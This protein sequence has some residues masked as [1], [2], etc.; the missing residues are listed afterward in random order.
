MILTISTVLVKIIGFLFT[1]PLLN[2]LGAEGMGYFYTAYEIYGLF[3]VV[4]TTGLP[5]AAAK[6]VSEAVTKKNNSLADA[7]FSASK[8]LFY[9]FGLVCAVAMFFFADGLADLLKNPNAALAMRAL[10]P[11][12]FFQAVLAAYRGYFQGKSNMIPT[13]ATQIIEAVLKLLFGV[14]AAYALLKL[15]YSNA[16]AA[17]GAIAGVSIGSV[18]AVIYLLFYKKKD[19][20]YIEGLSSLSTD[21]NNKHLIKSLISIAVPIT[22]GTAIFNLIGIIDTGIIMRRL[23]DA[24]GLSYYESNWLFGVYGNAKK[25]FNL[26]IAFIVPLSSSVI[27]ALSAALTRKDQ[28]SAKGLTAQSLKVTSLLAFPSGAGL[29]ALAY[30]IMNLIYF[31]SSEEIA[32]GAQL[33]SV[34]GIAVVFSSLVLITSSIIQVGYDV[35]YPAITMTIGG[36]I[37]I[38]LCWILVGNSDIGIIGAPI[39]TCVCYAVTAILNIILICRK[40]INVKDAMIIFIKIAACSVIMA[41]A[42]YNLNGL[43]VRAINAKIAC[44][45]SMILGVIIYGVL[46]VTTKLVT[47]DDFKQFPKGEKIANIL[48]IK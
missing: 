4:F 20:K 39:S 18:V 27:P 8:F 36:I 48:H 40:L 31:K 42:A 23:Q 32:I 19:D 1:I 35:K 30:P 13:A 17:A 16:F 38:G 21:I 22:L 14:G 9:L 7:I 37:K 26:P 41:V 47:R 43:L 25:L 29:F 44:I 33:L 34:L 10:A 3:T 24:I 5:V 11:M 12:V 15:G 6:M 46:A 45:L 2:M 28:K